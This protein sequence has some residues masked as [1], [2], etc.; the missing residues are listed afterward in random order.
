MV[1]RLIRPLVY[2][3]LMVLSAVFLSS[4]NTS[5]CSFP[6][7]LIEMRG[8]PIRYSIVD[9]GG[10][11]GIRAAN[12]SSVVDGA[13]QAAYVNYLHKVRFQFPEDYWNYP[14]GGDDV[15]VYINASYTVIKDWQTYKS[16][17]EEANNTIIVNTH[18]EILPIPNGYSKEEW[19]TVISDFLLN[20]WGTWVHTGGLPFRVVEHEDGTTEEW[21]NGFKELMAMASLNVTIRN[22]LGLPFS[23]ERQNQAFSALGDFAVTTPSWEGRSVSLSH[24]AYARLEPSDGYDYCY[25]FDGDE[26][27]SSIMLIYIGRCVSDLRA[28]APSAVFRLSVNADKYGIFVYSSPWRFMDAGSNYI[29]ADVCSIGMGVIPTAA[30]IWCEAGYAASRILEANVS[31]SKDEALLQSANE[32]FNAGRY[33]EAVVYAERSMSSRQLNILPSVVLVIIGTGVA[34]TS[35]IAYRRRKNGDYR[36]IQGSDERA[37][38]GTFAC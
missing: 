32:I 1:R 15:D 28:Y 22:P 7:A 25:S 13:T 17:V 35:G 26:V 31:S 21:N 10:V 14:S 23:M 3:Q 33:K 11:G 20:R 30:A 2:V 36:E 8:G 24:F 19:L 5:S 4:L 34:A 27:V 29:R 12:H 18:D 16:L 38:H 9:L 6:I 37:S